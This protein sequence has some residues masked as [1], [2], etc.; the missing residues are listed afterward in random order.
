M[1]QYLQS[2]PTECPA[3]GPHHQ[4]VLFTPAWADPLLDDLPANVEVVRLSGVSAN[5]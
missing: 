3:R 1:R 2:L 4:F 5:R